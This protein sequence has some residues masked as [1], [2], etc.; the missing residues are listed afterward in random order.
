MHGERVCRLQKIFR[1]I[2][3]AALHQFPRPPRSINPMLALARG[4]CGLL[5]PARRW[6]PLIWPSGARIAPR[7][8][9]PSQPL[10]RTSSRNGGKEST[11]TCMARQARPSGL[12]PGSTV[13]ERCDRAACLNDCAVTPHLVPGSDRRDDVQ[14]GVRHRRTFG[15]S[16][17][18]VR[19]EGLPREEPGLIRRIVNTCT[20]LQ[21]L[22]GSLIER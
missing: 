2:L 11:R 19:E 7:P 20:G 6:R 22:G 13:R 5:R 4:C 14:A 16:S 15:S 3:D 12:P 1:E 10:V 17:L 21:D 9:T 18:P 8:S